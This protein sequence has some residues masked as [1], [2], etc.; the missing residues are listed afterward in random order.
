MHD[1]LGMQLTKPRFAIELMGSFAVLAMILT[2]VGLYGVMLYSVS[3]RTREIGIRLALGAQRNSVLLMVLRESGA[4]LLFGT[5]IG[6]V[7]TVASTSI[8]RSML[9][10]TGTRNPFVLAGV[11]IVEVLIGIIAAFIPALRAASVQPVT[12]LRPK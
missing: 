3:R 8:L 9:Y 5:A 4:L 10:N 11:C 6:L 7:A 2:V 1:L 12:A